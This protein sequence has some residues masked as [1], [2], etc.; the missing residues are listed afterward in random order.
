MKKLAITAITLVF[1]IAA[2]PALA[3]QL[4]STANELAQTLNLNAESY[5]VSD[6][7]SGEILFFK[8]ADKQWVP[9]SLTKLLTVLVVLD[10]KPKLNKAVTMSSVDQTAGGCA[11]GGACIK[12]KPGV[13]FSVDTLIKAALLPS[14]NNAANALA[15]STG[16]SAQK[17]AEKMNEKAKILGA[18]NSY[19]VEPTGM[20]PENKITASD[21]AKITQA[22]FLNPYVKNI[23][24]KTSLRLLSLNN[25]KY[26]QT[27]KNTNKMLLD[28]ESKVVAAKTGFIDESKYNF[29]SLVKTEGGREVIITVLGEKSLNQA[30]SETKL[31]TSL[32]KTATD[33][34][35]LK[36]S[37]LVAGALTN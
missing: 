33:L 15:R 17:F 2:S 11:Q 6:F 31:L 23:A 4:P 19:F 26:H 5:M 24:T 32:V 9:A 18:K 10:T 29:S 27:V 30:F 16:F 7:K 1:F 8:D 34:A 35:L 14:A 28:P 36:T 25:S 37:G 21:Y 22:A 20:S 12:S 3:L 13:K